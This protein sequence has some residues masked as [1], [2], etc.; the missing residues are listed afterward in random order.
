MIDTKFVVVG[1][2]IFGSVI[3]ERIA[4]VLGEPVTIVERR[5]A[6]GGNCRSEFDSETRIEFHCYGSHIFHTSSRKVWEYLTRFTDFTPYRHKVVLISENHSYFMPVNL[7]TLNEVYGR[8]FSPAEAERHLAQNAGRANHSH[9]L[10]EKAVALV[11]R[12]CYEKLIRGYTRKQWNKEPRELPA[13]II[14]RLPVRTSFQTDYF[15]DIYQGMPRE[16]YGRLFEKMLRHPGIRVHLNTDFRTIQ[17]QIRADAM[18]IYTGMIDEFFDYSLGELEWRSLRFEQETLPVRDYQGTAVVNYADESIPYIRIHE[19]KH[20][21]PERV[22]P[23]RL[24]KS[25]ICREYPR[26]WRRGDE[27][28]YPINTTRN[29][30]LLEQYELLA[31]KYEKVIF[32]GRLGCYRYWNMDQA[33]LH[34]L[35]YFETRICNRKK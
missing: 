21:H 17:S 31:G 12:A 30:R 6:V 10:E 7:K 3:A 1:S 33:V 29:Q 28:F 26:E 25:V 20:Y 19:F 18:V 11:G 35:E 16:G 15:D 5:N 32:G 13:E 9:N 34:A 23:Y 22:E 4:S 2:G 24:A 8:V 14:D 27:A